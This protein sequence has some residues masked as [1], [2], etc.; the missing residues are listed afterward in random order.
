MY[1]L[2]PSSSE[3]KV[4]EFLTLKIDFDVSKKN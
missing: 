2:A 3:S 4:M 1:G